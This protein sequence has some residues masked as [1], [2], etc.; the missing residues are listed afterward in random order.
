MEVAEPQPAT[1]E[2]VTMSYGD[3]KSTAHSTLGATNPRSPDALRPVRIALKSMTVLEFLEVRASRP[4]ARPRSSTRKSLPF[5]V[6][7]GMP[8][9][10]MA[11]Q[12]EHD[13]RDRAAERHAN[14]R[15]AQ[16]ALR[17]KHSFSARL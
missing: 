6:S 11:G 17:R 1:N 5:L 8:A 14:R 10:T 16:E 15:R 12:G 4:A 7:I 9:A 13:A 3:E 2:T